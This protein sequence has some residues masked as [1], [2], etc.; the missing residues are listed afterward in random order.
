[1]YLYL[2]TTEKLIIG[3]LDKEFQWLDYFEED[4]RSASSRLQGILHDNISRVGKTLEDVKGVF[5]ASGPGSY[6]GMR[7]SEGFSQILDWHGYPVYSFYHFEVPRLLGVKKGTWNANAYK[8][9]VFLYH[10]D[11]DHEDYELI[12]IHQVKESEGSHL[13]THFHKEPFEMIDDKNLTSQMILDNSKI[14]FD[15][16]KSENMRCEP[17]YYRPIEVEFTKPTRKK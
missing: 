13:Y 15:I 5:Q 12:K 3:I 11:E 1:M 9:D 2:D 8:G 4:I 14:F 16:L 7:V 17:Y 6:T 10:W